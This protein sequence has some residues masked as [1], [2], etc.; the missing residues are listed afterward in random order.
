MGA[1]RGEYMLDVDLPGARFSSGVASVGKSES[2]G[3]SLIPA[4]E[5]MSNSPRSIVGRS[6]QRG[7]GQIGLNDQ[8]AQTWTA[9]E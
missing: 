8:L 7:R 1:G 4:Q 9:L 3:G 2:W 6:W 5:M